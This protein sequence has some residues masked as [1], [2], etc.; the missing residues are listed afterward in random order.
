MNGLQLR[1]HQALSRYYYIRGLY[2]ANELARFDEISVENS[3]RI[4][5]LQQEMDKAIETISKFLTDQIDGTAARMV[6]A[7]ARSVLTGT[8]T[9]EDGVETGLKVTREGRDT[10]RGSSDGRGTLVREGTMLGTT[11]PTTGQRSR[12]TVST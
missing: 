7:A 5:T 10:L 8:L 6:A 9:R 3:E 12:L 1:L 4:N 2:N 11:A